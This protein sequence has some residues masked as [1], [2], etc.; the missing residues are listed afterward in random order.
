MSDN[1]KQHTASHSLPPP[2]PPPPFPRTEY[3]AVLLKKYEEAIKD[4][5]T[6]QDAKK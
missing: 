6:T 1:I 4:E 5:G 2:P 3:K